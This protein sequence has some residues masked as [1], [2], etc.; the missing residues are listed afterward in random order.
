VGDQILCT[1]FLYDH[2]TM[3]RKG[4]YCTFRNLNS[5][6]DCVIEVLLEP[7]YSTM[8]KSTQQQKTKFLERKYSKLHLRFNFLFLSL[9]ILVHEVPIS[10]E[11]KYLNWQYCT[12]L[13]NL[14]ELG[15]E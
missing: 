15:T 3:Q 8:S 7:M 10:L 12:V 11:V 1:V 5:V 2:K 14:W 4:K 9:N 6:R 13:N